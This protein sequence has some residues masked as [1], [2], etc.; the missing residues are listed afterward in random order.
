MHEKRRK[1]QWFYANLMYYNVLVY[2][3]VTSATLGNK[4]LHDYVFLVIS[5]KCFLHHIINFLSHTWLKRKMNVIALQA[6]LGRNNAFC[7]KLRS[8]KNSHFFIVGSNQQ[9][10]S[11]TPNSFKI[12]LKIFVEIIINLAGWAILLV[13]TRITIR[14][15]YCVSENNVL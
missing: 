2:A 7:L 11:Y 14:N 12:H 9:Q 13:L 5:F 8:L 6:V 1:V 15:T 3:V 4:L 10:R